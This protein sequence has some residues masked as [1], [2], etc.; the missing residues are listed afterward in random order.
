MVTTLTS[1]DLKDSPRKLSFFFLKQ[2]LHL[3]LEAAMTGEKSEA[4]LQLL[5]IS[6]F[7]GQTH[8]HTKKCKYPQLESILSLPLAA[9]ERPGAMR[10]AR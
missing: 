7:L 5:Y 2:L 6:M 4:V 1:A 9:G 8:Q 3:W 10:T